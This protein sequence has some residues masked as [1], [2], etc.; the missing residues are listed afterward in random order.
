MPAFSETG[1]EASACTL[2][3]PLIK[4][5]RLAWVRIANTGFSASM[6]GVMSL[7]A[8][9]KS[10]W[11]QEPAEACQPVSRN[12]GNCA[13]ICR[14]PSHTIHTTNHSF[15]HCKIRIATAGFKRVLTGKFR[16]EYT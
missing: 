7:P 15:I 9:E 5:G 11:L 1:I 13:L 2:D 8:G 6:E 10:K 4:K 12:A 14:N 16:G 3:K